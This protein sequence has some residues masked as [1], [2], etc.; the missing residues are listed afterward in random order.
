MIVG[1]ATRTAKK[2]IYT[3]SEK[4]LNRFIREQFP[5]WECRAIEE[6]DERQ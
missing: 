6:L 1:E 3:E 2:R 5:E 4:A